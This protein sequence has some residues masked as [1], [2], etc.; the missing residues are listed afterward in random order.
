MKKIIL[1][2]ILLISSS[3]LLAGSHEMCSH[4]TGDAYTECVSKPN[5][6]R[7]SDRKLKQNEVI[8]NDALK[9]VTQLNGKHFEW[10]YDNR[11][12]IG[13]IAQE[14]EAIFPELV[15]VDKTTQFKQV[16]Y[17]GLIGVLIEAVKELKKE[18]DQLKQ[19]L[20]IYE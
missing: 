5:F 16:N 2:S 10:K 3:S 15:T 1:A 17:A 4:L 8:I 11:Q 6:L 20:G 19:Q 14:V 9:K 12:D 18:N 7:F 13:V